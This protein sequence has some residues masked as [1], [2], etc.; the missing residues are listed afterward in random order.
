MNPIIIND[1]NMAKI[2]AWIK[3]AEGK[4]TARTIKAQ[5][6]AD[7][8]QYIEK[9]LGI[10]KT[11]MEGVEFSVD[12][13]AQNFPNAYKYRAESTQFEVIRQ[14]GKWRVTNICRYFT[15]RA[16]HDYECTFMPET[17]KDAIIRSKMTF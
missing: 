5:D 13:H 16:G 6:I 4:A 14:G 17:T 10:A 2:E 8:C 15:R 12:I 1:G 9:T 3:E 7:A 11:H